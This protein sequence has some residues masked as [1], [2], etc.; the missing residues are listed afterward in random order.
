MKTGSKYI[1]LVTKEAIVEI[2]VNTIHKCSS[3]L[4][5]SSCV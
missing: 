5:W 2:S 4:L 3:R 1:W